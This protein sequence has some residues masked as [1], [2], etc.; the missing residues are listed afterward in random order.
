MPSQYGLKRKRASNDTTTGEVNAS[1]VTSSN[2]PDASS[3]HARTGREDTDTEEKRPTASTNTKR[4]R[5]QGTEAGPESSSQ[6]KNNGNKVKKKP[7]CKPRK[8]SPSSPRTIPWP[9]SFKHLYQTHR[10]LNL[11]YTFCST[12]K[13][14][15][16]TFDNIR[17]AVQAQLGRGR[18]LAVED[19]A[20][21]RA[22]VPG[23]VR[24]EFVDGDLLDVMS[25]TAFGEMEMREVREYGLDRRGGYDEKGEEVLLFEFVDADL[26]KETK[27]SSMSS[28]DD[29]KMPVYSHKQMLA[30]IEKRNAK[31]TEAIN[32]FLVKCED[33]GTDPVEVLEQKKDSFIPTSGTETNRS[34]VASKL[35]PEIPKERKAIADI[36]AEIREEEWYTAQIVPDGHRVLDAQPAVYDDLTFQLS[37]NLVN[38]LYNAKGITQIYSH[39]AEA[40]NNLYEGHNVIVSTSTSSGKSLIYQ[41]PMLHELEKDPN[42]R[43]MYIF[44]TK[45]LA[46]DQRGGMKDMLQYLD[47][48]LQDTMV[49]TYDGDTPMESRWTI[50]DEARVIFTNPDMLHVSILP[51]EGSWRAFLEN[52][53]FVVVDELHVYNGLFGSHVALIM[54]RLRRV[55]AAV[56]N[57]HVKFISCSATVANPEE[58]MRTIFGIDDVKLIDFDGSPSGRKEF[59]CWNTPFK[60]PGDPTSG[61]GDCV[62]ETARVFCQLM[63]RGVR[64]IAFARI[65]KLCESLL[66]AVRGELYRLER[67]E[68]GN[69]VMGYRGGYSPQDRRRI[70]REMFEGKLMGIVATNALELGVD[71]GSLDA[72]ITMGFPY[73]IS[74]LRQQSGRAGR[75]NKDSLS[76]LVGDRYPTD[77]YYMN[78]PDE[79]FTKPNCELQVDLSNELVL[80]GHIQCAAFEMPIR[81]D[82]DSIYFGGKLCEI[83]RTRLLQDETHGFYHCHERFK[84]QPFRCVPIRDTEDQQFAIIDTTN[85][86]N[87]VLEEI[88]ASRALFTIYEGGIFLHQGQPYLITELNPDRHLARIVRVHVDWSTMQRDYTDIDPV[89]TECQRPITSTSPCRAFYGSIQVH[90]VVYGFFKVDKRG[91]ILDAVAVDNPPIDILSKGMWL[92]VPME[93]LRILESRHLNIAAAIHAAEHAVLSLLPSFV[94]SSPGDVRTECK[95]AKKELPSRHKPADNNGNNNNPQKDL[96]PPHRTRPARLTFYDAKGGSCGSGIAGKAFE[97]IDVLLTRAIS[98]IEHCDCLTPQGCVECVCDERCKEMNVVMS[99]AGAGVVLRCLLGLEVDVEGLP[100]GVVDVDDGDGGELAGGLETVVP[101][102][103]I[104]GKGKRG[105]DAG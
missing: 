90:S 5:T 99:K 72:V 29:L 23:A 44:P 22:L 80:E 70:E 58:H 55:C 98:R 74:N 53:K 45:A 77:Q 49:E 34:A 46:Q 86:R 82:E 87:L 75:R 15:A 35:P 88:E 21:I 39:Q 78:N 79:L 27:S 50:R 38:A 76:V 6:N 26:K 71:I 25:A 81:P 83:A 60:D 102:R 64:V 9:D 103:E 47:G 93:A 84:P 41:V 105:R 1:D 7:L 36:I 52:L 8:P 13:H 67:A 4:A 97:F 51:H 17:D 3:E 61:R 18:K 42:S 92:D 48:G 57:N 37:Q 62:A 16:T 100:W 33:D 2:E 31:F 63:L 28:G 89:E 94:V 32:T 85:N 96:N 20:R 12:R 40:I 14:F 104:P 68:T 43:G 19:V 54:R 10:A 30:L 66:Q 69:L 11:V 65:R 73:S 59:L 95:V 24:F 91:R 56:G 101:A